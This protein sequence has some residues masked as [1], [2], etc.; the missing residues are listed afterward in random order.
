M[1]LSGYVEGVM[2]KHLEAD[3]ET[4]PQA[5]KVKYLEGQ[6]AEMQKTLSELKKTTA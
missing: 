2:K 6:M 5:S 4:L 3:G 1:N